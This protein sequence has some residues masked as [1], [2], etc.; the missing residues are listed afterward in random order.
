MKTLLL[1]SSGMQIKNEIL[2]ILP[3]P[4]NQ[5]KL[6]HVITASKPEAD[7]TY[8]DRD[9]KLLREVGFQ[10]VEIDIEGRSEKELREILHDFDILYVQGGNTFYLLKA[11]KESGFG[12]VIKEFINQGKIYIGVSA[13]SIIMGPTIETANWKGIDKNDVGLEDLTAMNIIPFAI[14]PHYDSGYEEL[15][16]QEA[17]RAKNPA[18]LLTDDQAFL[19]QDD[20]ITLLGKG[21]EIR[22]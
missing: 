2:K 11:V 12:A 9:T 3:K 16:K 8:R 1:T 6:A 7:T 15:V 14:F 4:A 19:V 18:R 13:G 22:L 10:A 5:L 21:E 20:K 17:P